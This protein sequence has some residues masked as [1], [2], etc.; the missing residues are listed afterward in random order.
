MFNHAH[1]GDYN[2][3]IAAKG[4]GLV[5]SFNKSITD[6]A[7]FTQ[8]EGIQAVALKALS[9]GLLDAQFGDHVLRARAAS[10]VAVSCGAHKGDA[11]Y[12]RA[13]AQ[14]AG[15]KQTMFGGGRRWFAVPA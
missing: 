13:R 6:V 7:M 3:T 8:F 1:Q 10:P 14:V 12:E 9:E 5:V 11:M 4:T 15:R 2:L